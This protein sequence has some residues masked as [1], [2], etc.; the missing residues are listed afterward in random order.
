MPPAGGRGVPPA[1]LSASS[2]RS[3][4]RISL[5]PRGILPELPLHRDNCRANQTPQPPFDYYHTFGRTNSS[6]R[7]IRSGALTRTSVGRLLRAAQ[8]RR[9]PGHPYGSTGHRQGYPN[10]GASMA[11]ARPCFLPLGCHLGLTD[12]PRAYGVSAGA[13]AGR[14]VTPCSMERSTT[15]RV[16]TETPGP[17]LRR[18]YVRVE[19]A[20]F[21]YRKGDVGADHYNK[22]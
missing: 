11:R 20:L 10:P 6:F 5:C 18:W 13:P 17:A 15:A 21:G 19:A 3:R 1:A 12:A 14:A 4:N 9:V 8:R 22:S 16:P 2:K 7:R